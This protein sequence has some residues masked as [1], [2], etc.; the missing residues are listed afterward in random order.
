MFEFNE[1]E[2]VTMFTPIE[3]DIQK[4]ENFMKEARFLELP[5]TIRER[6]VAALEQKK[7]LFSKIR[8]HLNSIGVRTNEQ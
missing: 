4:Y 2:L 5:E 1:I 3:E 6:Y 7:N 8:M